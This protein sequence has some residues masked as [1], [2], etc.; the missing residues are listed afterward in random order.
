MV[1][2]W[3]CSYSFAFLY[4]LV[5]LI[6]FI[7][8]FNFVRNKTK[9]QVKQMKFTD[10]WAHNQQYF[11][12][13]L[14]ASCLYYVGLIVTIDDGSKL[15]KGKDKFNL[16]GLLLQHFGTQNRFSHLKIIRLSLLFTGTKR[17]FDKKSFFSSCQGHTNVLIVLKNEFGNVIGYS[18]IAIIQPTSNASTNIKMRY[19]TDPNAFLFRIRSCT[20]LPP[21]IFKFKT[22]N[23]KSYQRAIRISS[24]KL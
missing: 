9:K 3:A 14:R 24:K 12:H 21:Q 15:L 19:L 23:L 7:I 8:R 17:I 4:L 16:H 10:Y 1:K 20:N 11:I 18:S 5:F 2:N 13:E 6:W 22:N